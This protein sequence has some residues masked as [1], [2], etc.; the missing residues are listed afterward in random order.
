MAIPP[1]FKLSDRV[2]L[3]PVLHG[4]GDFA[5]EVRRMLLENR[6][7]CVAVPLPPSFQ[8]DV[9]AAVDD[10]PTIHIVTQ[11]AVLPR[12]WE[13]GVGGDGEAV[14]ANEELEPEH[15][16]VPIDPCQPV[17]AALRF[18]IAERLPR[19]FIDLETARFEPRTD[20][21][22]DP[23]AL[24]QV[25]L[26]KFAATLLVATSAPASGQPRARVRTMARRLRALEETHRSVFA[27]VSLLDWP[28]VRE[29]F[30]GAESGTENDGP[31]EDEDDAVEPTTPLVVDPATLLFM[32][33][34]LPY[35]TGLYERARRELGDDEN[36]SIDGVKDLLLEARSRYRAEH[37]RSARSISPHLL[38]LYLKYARNLTLMER[39]FTPDLYTLVV[40]AQQIAG[41]QF[42]LQVAETARDYDY[43]ERSDRGAIQFGIDQARLPNGDV[44]RM[45]SRLPGPPMSW[46]NCDLNRRPERKEEERWA[47]GWNPHRQ[48]SWP[49][50]DVAIERF[51]VHCFDRAREIISAD[52]AKSEKFTTSIRDGID[53]R[54]TLRNWHAGEIYVK[55]FPPAIGDL[56][57]LVMLFDAPADPRDYPYRLTWYAEHEEESTLAFFATDP[58][59][60]LVGPKI[61]RGTYGGCLLLFPPLAIRDV[62]HDRELD[63]ALSLED[64][65]VAA[66]CRYSRQR[67]V[68]LLSSAPPGAAWRRMARHHGKRFVHLPLARFGRSTVEQ[69]RVFHVLDGHEVRS[70]ASKFIHKR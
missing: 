21:F 30:L 9:E 66:A 43:Q 28:W 54:E 25:P 41:D 22:P 63:S 69:L 6:F 34:E 46:R 24:K 67:H 20:T 39:R 37:Q 49:P 44:V 16:Y 27:V 50:E 47:Q 53:I 36:L 31:G 52:L 55:N 42:A 12:S 7:D 23:Y 18:A 3:L 2:T 64:R 15:S 14:G 70:Y 13:L 10:L 62:W 11:E 29:A 17:I 68:A 33:G 57:C 56:D 32:L 61:A 45:V 19:A 1:I 8:A 65:L 35:I 26:E 38:S 51:R 5:L 48:C 59:K 60:D 40:A 58:M 4:S